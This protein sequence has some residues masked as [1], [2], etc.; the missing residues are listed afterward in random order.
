M[1]QLT[2]QS[3]TSGA[4]LSAASKGTARTLRFLLLLVISHRF[5]TCPEADAYFIIQSLTVLF[6]TLNE[7]VFNLTLIPILVDEHAKKGKLEAI[8]LASS[9]F[10][11]LNLFFFGVSLAIFLAAV[12]LA[13]VMAPGLSTEGR[14]FTA[15][16]IRIVAPI[17]LLAGLGGVPASIFYAHRSFVLPNV[18]FLFY[19]ISSIVAALL[20]A[21]LVGIECVPMGAAFGVLLQAVV[22][23]A[24]LVRAGKL[25]LSFRPHEGLRRLGKLI[26]PRISGRFLT[27]FNMVVD[28]LLATRIGP[29]QA[30]CL[31]YA[32]RM[33]QLPL[34]ILI[35]PLAATMP[36]LSQQ[37]AVNDYDRMRDF[38]SRM[39]RLILFVILPVTA[40]LL[41]LHEPLVGCLFERGAFVRHD[42]LTASSALFFYTLGLAFMS[43]NI[44]AGSAFY[45][46]HDGRTPLLISIACAVLNVLFD[47]LLIPFFDL[48][49]IALAR[50]A[51]ALVRF[52]LTFTWLQKRIGILPWKEQ[53]GR[54]AARSA[55]AA[56]LAGVGMWIVVRII[57]DHW[58]EPSYLLLLV[59]GT[60]VGGCVYLAV[61]RLSGAVEQRELTE[62][63]RQ[64]LRSDR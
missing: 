55:L 8:K 2:S 10:A 33:N 52:F 58:Q 13:G 40:W 12:P 24:I 11:Y 5:G 34:S 3:L 39:L 9:A 18:T 60:L 15:F 31:T 43:V 53:I 44:F 1:F 17:P 57:S 37:A 45:A 7:T 29:G 62:L 16:L 61:S 49:G 63:L 6:L 27:I 59:G 47:L 22:L 28:K 38:M 54:S 20:L 35:A 4:L 64:R 50:S 51:T 32:L 19:G 26:V 46:L 42:T 30:S 48:S 36:R 41:A 56:A 14:E 25:S 23:I 21:D